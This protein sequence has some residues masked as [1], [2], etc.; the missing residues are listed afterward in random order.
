MAHHARPDAWVVLVRHG[1]TARWVE[2]LKDPLVL[3][4]IAFPLGLLILMVVFLDRRQIR[5]LFWF[6]LIWGSLLTTL[7]LFIFDDVFNLVKYQHARPFTIFGLPLLFDL[8]WTPAIIMF[9][10]FLPDRKIRYAFYT[11]ILLFCILNASNDEVFHQIG[12][13]KYVHWSPIV[14]FLISLPYFYWVAIH[15]L[16]LKAK[17]V[18]AGAKDPG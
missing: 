10:H 6:G 4:Y 11:Y 3:Y 14:R 2:L 13:L 9:V 15:Y 5:S 7:L 1:R 17:G 18:F 8:A 16:N 12:L